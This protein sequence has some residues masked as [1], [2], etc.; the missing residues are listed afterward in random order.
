MEQDRPVHLEINLGGV[1]VTDGRIAVGAVTRTETPLTDLEM[2]DQR[3]RDARY[4]AAVAADKEQQEAE[5]EAARNH[6]DPLVRALAKRAG[7]L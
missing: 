5:R 2:A 6:P 1:T 3:D 4:H 7:L